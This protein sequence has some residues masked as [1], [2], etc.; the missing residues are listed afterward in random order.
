MMRRCYNEKHKY[1]KDYGGRGIYVCER[2]KDFENF[3]QDNIEYVNSNLTL[4][5]ADNELGYSKENCRW[6]D[7]KAQNN[8]RR[9]SVFLEYRG[10]QKTLKQWAEHFGVK[11]Q[12]F[13]WRVKQGFSIEVAG[14]AI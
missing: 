13:Y 11:Y 14:G 8:N 3:Y 9:S 12:T 4:D 6:V 10:V 2:W 1:Y 5:R 7:M